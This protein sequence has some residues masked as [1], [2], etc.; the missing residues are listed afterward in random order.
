MSRTLAIA[1]IIPA[2]SSR[3]QN[4][5]TISYSFLTFSPSYLLFKY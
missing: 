3:W 1:A 4:T 5:Y 2:Q